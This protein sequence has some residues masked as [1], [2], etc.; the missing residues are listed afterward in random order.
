MF[1]IVH[2]KPSLVLERSFPQEYINS[3][4]IRTKAVILEPWIEFK[5]KRWQKRD[6]SIFHLVQKQYLSTYSLNWYRKFESTPLLVFLLSFWTDALC[7]TLSWRNWLCRYHPVFV[8]SE[9]QH[10]LPGAGVAPLWRWF[11]TH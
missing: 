4:F 7:L 1:F 6:I 11:S 8:S 10:T 9:P 3:F 2:I 5:F